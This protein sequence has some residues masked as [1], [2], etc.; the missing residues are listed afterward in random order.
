MRNNINFII[1]KSMVSDKTKISNGFND[2]FVKV[3]S[4][5]SRNIHC[6]V[7]PLAYVEANP[8][9]MV[10]PNLTVGDI[11]NVNSLLNNYYYYYF[12]DFEQG[13]TT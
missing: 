7:N 1:D 3:D 8:N 2:Y 12:K 9:T 4:T 11:I 5:L 10:I 6:D 13:M